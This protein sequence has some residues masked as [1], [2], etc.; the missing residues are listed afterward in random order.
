MV[1]LLDVLAQDVMG[2]PPSDPAKYDPDHSRSGPSVAGAQLEGT[3][4]AAY[5]RTRPLAN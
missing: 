1:R 5:E 3:P 4:A 2:A